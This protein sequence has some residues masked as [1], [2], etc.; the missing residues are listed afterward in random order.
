MDVGSVISNKHEFVTSLS[1]PPSIQD[2]VPDIRVRIYQ[3]LIKLID[4]QTKALKLSRETRSRREEKNR[5]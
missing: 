4:D 1:P 3:T 5:T 2:H